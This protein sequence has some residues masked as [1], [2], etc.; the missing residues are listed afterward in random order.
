MSLSQPTTQP[1]TTLTTTQWTVVT[2]L[3]LTT[4]QWM[5]VTDSS[6]LRDEHEPKHIDAT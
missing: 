5:V 6:Y 2:G 1:M 4:T 3:T